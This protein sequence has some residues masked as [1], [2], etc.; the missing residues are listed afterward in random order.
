MSIPARRLV[1]LAILAAMASLTGC[2]G[3]SGWA[4]DG[5]Y[6]ILLSKVQGP[7]HIERAA[8]TRD[9][10]KQTGWK[11]LFVVNKAGGSQL[12]TGKFISA[13]DALTE[14][15]RVRTYQNQ[16]GHR[17]FAYATLVALP[18]KHIG[19]DEWDLRNASG[20]LYT[21]QVATYFDAPAEKYF[22]R[23]RAAVELCREFRKL[24]HEAYYYHGKVRSHV[25]IGVFGESATAVTSVRDGRTPRT[26]YR[27]PRINTIIRRFPQ[28]NINGNAHAL[29]PKGLTWRSDKGFGKKKL[30]YVEPF[31]VKIPK[32]RA[33]HAPA[34]DSPAG[35]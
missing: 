34:A 10:L 2:N 14:L 31:P 23:R 22:G 24:G 28:H 6:S 17:P 27:D 11:H 29:R 20:G 26:K 33:K 19:P 13:D 16:A 9:R 15:K 21:I 32:G 3:P 12:F 25:T 8:F 35:D 1:A 7:N 30:L 4:P 5:E 18:G